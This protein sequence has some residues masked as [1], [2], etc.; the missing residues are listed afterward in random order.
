MPSLFS[1]EFYLHEADK[2]LVKDDIQMYL[3][4]LL[5]KIKADHD[6][7]ILDNWPKSLHSSTARDAVHRECGGLPWGFPGQ[8]APVPVETPTP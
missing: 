4:T 7:T 5:A 1:S 8:P 2:D 6:R 3:E